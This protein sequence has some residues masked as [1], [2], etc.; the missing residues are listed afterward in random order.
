MRAFVDA[1]LSGA[2]P[3]VT[4]ADGCAAVQVA[5]AANKSWLE[6]T[7]VELEHVNV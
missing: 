3:P 5:R 1:A 2:A 6:A 4:A 7:P